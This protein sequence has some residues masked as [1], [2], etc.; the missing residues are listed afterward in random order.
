[1]ADPAASDLYQAVRD[2]TLAAWVAENP[3]WRND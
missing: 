2:S 3:R 1:V